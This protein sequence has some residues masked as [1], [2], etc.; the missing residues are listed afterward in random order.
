M[1]A[2]TRELALQTKAVL[3]YF[4]ASRGL[5][6]ATLVGGLEVRQQIR[7]LA[8]GPELLV[9]TPGRLLDHVER[10][11]LDLGLIRELVLDESDHMMDLGFLPQ[12]Q[13]ILARVPKDRQTLMFSATMPE[14]ILRLAARGLREPL[15]VDVTP[16][17]R[18]AS[19]LV[20]RLY[21][22]ELDQKRACVLSLLAHEQ[23][24][25]VVFVRR[26]AEAECLY[27]QL[28]RAGY[29]VGRL[30][31]DLSQ[32]E[33]LRSLAAFREGRH[34]IL[35]ATNVAARGL[36]IPEIRRVVHFDLP[37][38]VEEYIHRSGRTAR[39][40]STGV[41]STI[42]TWL[43]LEAIRAI[44]RALGK[45]LERATVAGVVPYREANSKRIRSPLRRR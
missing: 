11:S 15:T 39:G 43:D 22:V 30:H 2:P 25:T 9:A 12:L 23:D 27:K 13:R 3:D 42:A 10:G 5:R 44:E 45:P 4:G 29:P 19:G 20:H 35:I 8:T 36:D 32:T 37:D 26:R 24:A 7:A 40:D 1:L 16:P 34:R 31:A 18:A 28:Q 38:S 17:G 33:R 14:P 6:A 41:V 21:L